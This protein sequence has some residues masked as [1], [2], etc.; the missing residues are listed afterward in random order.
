MIKSYIFLLAIFIGIN[1]QAQVTSK[2]KYKDKDYWVY[3][4]RLEY[5]DEIPQAPFALPDGDY[6]VFHTYFFKNKGVLKKKKVLADTALPSAFI[7]I[8]NGTVNG[9]ATIYNYE[10]RGVYLKSKKKERIHTGNYTNG[11]KEGPWRT[12]MRDGSYFVDEYQGDLQNGYSLEYDKNKRLIA[13]KK[14]N[15]GDIIDTVF[16]YY[17][18]GQIQSCYDFCSYSEQDN[19]YDIYNRIFKSMSIIPRTAGKTFYKEYDLSGKIMANYKFTNRVIMPFDSLSKNNRACIITKL[20]Q[21]TVNPLIKVTYR[22]Y[23]TGKRRD[24]KR[25]GYYDKTVTEEF[26]RNNVKYKEVQTYTFDEK[27]KPSVSSKYYYELDTTL[28]PE[29]PQILEIDSSYSVSRQFFIPKYKFTYKDDGTIRIVN[30]DE[31]KKIIYMTDTISSY[32]REKDF[33]EK[34]YVANDSSYFRAMRYAPFY[35][36]MFITRENF[37]E[38]ETY[39]GR[40]ENYNEEVYDAISELDEEA[41]NRFSEYT[42]SHTLYKDEKPFTGRA[43]IRSGYFYFNPQKNDT[44]PVLFESGQNKRSKGAVVN[45]KKQGV[46]EE[47]ENRDFNGHIYRKKQRK[48]KN[49]KEDYFK[50]PSGFGSYVVMPYQ[51]G[52]KNGSAIEY[53]YEYKSNMRSY[54]YPEKKRKAVVDTLWKKNLSASKKYFIYKSTE[55]SF[56]NDTLHGPYKSYYDDGKLALSVFFDMG[57][58]DGDFVRYDKGGKIIAKGH[59]DKGKLSG[60]FVRYQE[61]ED[62]FEEMITLL[63]NALKDLEKELGQD[64]SKVFEEE[65]QKNNLHSRELSARFENNQLVDTLYFYGVD[66]KPFMSFGFNHDTVLFKKQFFDGAQIKEELLFSKASKYVIDERIL[67]STNYID[68][69]NSG[70]DMSFRNIETQYRSYYDNGQLLAVGNIVAGNP[71]GEWKFYNVNGTLVHQIVF[72][73]SVIKLP[74]AEKGVDISGMYTGYYSNGK[75]RAKGYLK[76]IELNYDCFTKQDKPDLDFYVIDFYDITGKQTIVNGSGYYNKYDENGLRISTGMLNNCIEDSVWKYYT[77][78]QKLTEIGMFIDGKRDGIWYEGDLEGINFEDGAC[79]DM[80]D[81]YAVKAYERKRKELEFT[82]I[83]YRK[84]IVEKR[85]H[86]RSDM[87]KTQDNF[88]YYGDF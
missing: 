56:K 54:I 16:Y 15:H 28:S 26:Y 62:G 25:Y 18:T 11:L 6:I 81:A 13:K 51:N 3:P 61:S 49:F 83:Y 82:K 77:P 72:A 14:Y 35:K 23:Y 58:P 59:F 21:D 12:T 50:N 20:N 67:E 63:G 75:L 46:W 33:V 52:F 29:I 34:M 74:G 85:T 7:T 87:N 86:F 27:L 47:L 60:D 57:R 70:Q 76:D 45:G 79:F 4:F 41:Y 43:E 38:T 19:S 36:K 31:T 17:P 71:Q 78:E 39:M 8:K 73:D 24:R 32:S 37:P 65:K 42:I 84:G 5:Q 10:G 66:D 1:L 53:S 88:N 40:V 30:I 68:I 48:L 22:Q 2:Y 69:I 9:P 80:N 44:L 55:L 64:V